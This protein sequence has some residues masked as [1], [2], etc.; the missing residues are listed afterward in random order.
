MSP[1]E[2]ERLAS[3]AREVG[4]DLRGEQLDLFARYHDL[5]YAWNERLN[6]TRVPAAQAVSRHYLDSLTVARAFDAAGARRV[7][8]V[9]TGAGL[10]GIPLK[11]AYPHLQVTLLDATR[12]K[13][14]FLDEV[15]ASL[16]LQG[17]QT[18]HARAEEASRSADHRAAYDIAVARAVGPLDRIAGWLLPFVRPGGVAVAMKSADVAEEV[19]AA[20]RALRTAAGTLAGVLRLRVPGEEVERSLVLLAPA[21]AS[22]IDRRRRGTRPARPAV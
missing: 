13:L 7:I 22:R 1:E 10:P 19:Q 16:C 6:L 12:K 3:G 21:R 17:I 18:V 14:T 5:L 2:R 20:S 9:G 11:I 8:D 4:I 15:I